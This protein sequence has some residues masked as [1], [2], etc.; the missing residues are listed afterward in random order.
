MVKVVCRR[1]TD[2]MPLCARGMRQF[3]Y[4][5]AKASMLAGQN[6]DVVLPGGFSLINWPCEEIAPRQYER[7][8]LFTGKPAAYYIFPIRCVKRQFPDI[9][10]GRTW[11]PGSLLRGHTANGSAQIRT[12][13]G[14]LVEGFVE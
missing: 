14:F 11:P 12:M 10:P 5:C 2:H 8:A 4:H 1:A 9:V 13:P 3:R 6:L 7:R